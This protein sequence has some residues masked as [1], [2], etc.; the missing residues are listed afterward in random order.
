[1]SM[2]VL[3]P[4]QPTLQG[5]LC[6]LRPFTAD[7]IAA[8]G[9]ILSDPEVGRLTGSVHSSAEAAAGTGR[10]DDRTLQWYRTRPLQRDRLDLAV[11][12]SAT[13]ECVGEAV[14]NDWRPDDDVCNFRI[15][16]GAA[17]RDRGIGSEAT[18]LLIDHGFA[19]TGLHRIELEVYA[20]NP[21][22][23]RAYEKAGFMA[24]GIQREVFKF[25]GRYIDAI[26]MSILRPE[27]EARQAAR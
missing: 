20:F 21:R 4:A 13:G 23:R 26:T 3:F 12:D 15:L 19:A 18:S 8:M 7:D 14:L 22:A 11:I 2:P 9:P 1:M 17:G 16:L 27:W 25:D 5:G 10:L 6:T 24:E